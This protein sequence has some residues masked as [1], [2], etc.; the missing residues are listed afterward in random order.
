MSKLSKL[1]FLILF[2]FSI[3]YTETDK[4]P[5]QSFSGKILGYKVRLRTKPDLESHIIAQMN[6]DDLL[7]IVGEEDDFWKIAP[8]QETKAYV[9]RSFVLDGVVEVNRVN[10]RLE[11]STE[12]PVIAQL[13]K[14]DKV[15]GEISKEDHKW[16][17][18]SPPENTVFYIAK[19][20]VGYAGNEAY[21]VTMNRKKEEVKELLNKAYLY[22]E[23]ECKKPFNQMMP[24]KATSLF[25]KII[26]EYSEFE[27][28]VQQAKEGLSLLQ[29]SYLQ[30]KIAF[31]EQKAN[32]EENKQTLVKQTLVASKEITPELVN[33]TPQPINNAPP[34][35]RMDLWKSTETALFQK[36]STFHPKKTMDDFY[37]EQKINSISVTGVVRRYDHKVKNKPGDFI[38]EGARAPVGYL[39]ST[40]VNLEKYEGQKVSLLVSPR[41]NHHFAFPAYFVIESA[42]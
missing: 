21:I 31:L 10:V 26:E 15:Q 22:T 27:S 34:S 28:F 11:P 14:G 16:I 40:M 36:W 6:K 38:L 4:K 1:S 32:V 12:S 30:K 17:T 9:F 20:F 39:Y 35:Q 18:I 7:L 29:D 41:S 8:P 42:E 3:A 13:Q 23:Q 33:K 25:E 2:V 5:F 19:E 24:E 37:K